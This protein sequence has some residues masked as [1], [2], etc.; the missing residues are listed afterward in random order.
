M[1]I[2]VTGYTGVIGKYLGSELSLKKY[3]VHVWPASLHLDLSRK[4]DVMRYF[5]LYIGDQYFDAVIH[6]ATKG[7]SDPR[8][9]DWSIMDTNLKMY[10]NLLS[11]RHKYKKFISIGSGAEFF[12]NDKPYGLSKKVI[13][14]SMLEKEDFYNL[15]VFGVF[16]ENELDTR[17]IKANV[18][19]YLRKEPIQIH[20]D[21]YMDFVYMEDLLKIVEHY[22]TGVNLKKEVDCVYPNTYKLS[23]IANIINNLDDHKVEVKVGTEE[24]GEGYCAFTKLV[25]LD[26]IGLEQ[27][28]RNV[29]NKLK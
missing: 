13:R 2:L 1:N 28:I 25:D 10:Y 24:L 18:L 4:E 9:T 6:C 12:M 11:Y 21:K 22:L 8:S 20:Q 26:F 16:N 23:D 3:N 5:D 29:Y 27:G 15:R 17:F 14:M 19:R 7:S